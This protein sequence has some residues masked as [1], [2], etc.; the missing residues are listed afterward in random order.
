LLEV[1]PGVATVL[2]GLVLI[3]SGSRITAM[4]GSW[5]AILAGLWFVIGRAVAPVLGIGSVGDPVAASTLK[6]A[7]LEIAYFTGLGSLIVFVGAVALTRLASRLAIDVEALERVEAAREEREA[8]A[9]TP[10]LLYREPSYFSGLE[11]A[12]HDP[13]S[14]ALTKPRTS[15]GAGTGRRAAYLRWPH[16]SR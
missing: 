3:L 4:L 13:P 5:L 16:P 14:D 2:A 7:A 12:R 15:E 1:L 8:R 11:E 9:A 6:R 10:S